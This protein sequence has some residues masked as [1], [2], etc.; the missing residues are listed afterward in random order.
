[1]QL[2][3]FA[4]FVENAHKMT[5]AVG[6]KRPN[7]W[8]LYDMHG[9]VGEWVLDPYSDDYSSAL[10]QEDANR[11]NYGSGSY[12]VIRGGGWYGGARYLRSADRYYWGPGNRGGD[13]GFRLVRTKN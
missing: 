9:N 1:M 12:R 5:H 10:S 11:G 3:E 7:P 13:V 8:G 2:K 6:L 4:W